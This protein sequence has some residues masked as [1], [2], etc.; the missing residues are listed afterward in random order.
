MIRVAP[1]IKVAQV[2]EFWQEAKNNP[3]KVKKLLGQKGYP[4]ENSEVIAENAA[5]GIASNVPSAEGGGQL[6]PPVPGVS[7]TPPAAG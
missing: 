4:A 2:Q 5:K 3:D 7:F 6:Q 1:G